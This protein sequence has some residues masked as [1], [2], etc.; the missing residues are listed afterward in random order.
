MKRSAIELGQVY[1]AKV[2][3][4][5]V[6][7]RID[8]EHADGGW[9]ATNVKTNRAVHIKDADRLIERVSLQGDEATELWTPTPPTR[10][11]KRSTSTDV[12]T[13]IEQRDTGERDVSSDEPSERPMSL[14][15]AAAQILASV[16]GTAMRCPELVEAA[17]AQG[18]WIP[19]SGKTPANTLH[20]A[21]TREIAT[22]GI[23]SRFAKADRGRF[24]Q[25]A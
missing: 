5:T 17:I 14:L 18:L 3:G 24:K 10:A 6:P 21:I 11:K 4:K 22:R 8:S 12:S 2:T 13:A 7:V 15:D 1:T 16:G 19:R 20:A 23:A 25:N 9:A